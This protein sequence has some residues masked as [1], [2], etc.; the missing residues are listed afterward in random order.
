[1]AG[2]AVAGMQGRIIAR[3]DGRFAFEHEPEVARR[4]YGINFCFSALYLTHEQSDRIAERLART[5]YNTLRI[6]HHEGELISAPRAS[7]QIESGGAPTSEDDLPLFEA[8]SNIGDNYATRIRG[9]VHPPETGEYVF[10]VASDDDSTLLLSTD[11]DP[12]NKRPAASVAGWT[13]IREWD[14]YDTQKSAPVA[15]EA[16]RKY[17]VEVVHREGSGGDHVAVGWS[18]PG[19]AGGVIT[20]EFLSPF[21]G[22]PKGSVAREV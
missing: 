20:G 22:G 21:G 3:E 7:D 12:A 17:Y 2:G 14:K 18:G 9:Y 13:S 19:V 5:G 11:D 10:V 8:P 1:V 15:L 16:G 4:F 6:H